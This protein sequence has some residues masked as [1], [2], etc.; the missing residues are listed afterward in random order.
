MKR[1]ATPYLF[2]LPYL[3]IFAL[4][5][6]WPILESLLLSFQNT[7]VSPP[8]WNL[9]VNWGRILGDAAFWDALRNTVLILVIQVPLM[10]ALATALAVALNSQLLRARGFFRFAFFAP[11]V[12]GAV[13]YSAVFRLLF[14][15][16][17][18]VNAALGTQINWIFDPVGAM[19]VI[20]TTLTWRWTGYNAIIILAGLQS[21]PK[22]LYEAAEIDGASPWQQFWRITVPSLRPVLLFCLVLSIIGTLQLFTEPWLITNGGPG[23]A[24]TTLGVYL[25]RQGFQNINFGY[26]STI[27]YAIT[28]LALVF[29]V[30]QLRLFGRES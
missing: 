27:A 7:R 29:S 14:N 10:L 24:T 4:F 5:W 26:A 2:L 3:A 15:Q 17:G 30:I 21:I 18:A 25:Y 6:A 11:V 13:A 8:V 19:A 9:G 1:S 22:D 28:L 12:V 23:T 20:I 16:N